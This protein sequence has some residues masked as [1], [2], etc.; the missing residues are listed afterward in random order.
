MSEADLT[1]PVAKAATF[2]VLSEPEAGPPGARPYKRRRVA[3]ATL[4]TV[5]LLLLAAAPSA[6]A[7]PTV[8]FLG[9]RGSGEGSSGFGK[10]VGPVLATVN[11]QLSYVNVGNWSE[12]S[13]YPAIPVNP[14]KPTFNSDYIKSVDDGVAGLHSEVA[15]FLSSCSHT[16]LLLAG[17][18][19]GAEVVDDWLLT[20]NNGGSNVI[21]VALL[22]DPRFNTNNSEDVGTNRSV[23]GIAPLQFADWDTFPYTTGLFSPP[24]PFGTWVRYPNSY[25]SSLRSFCVSGDP[26][27]GASSIGRVLSCLKNDCAHFHYMTLDVPSSLLTVPYKGETYTT[28]AGLWLAQRFAA[29]RTSTG[30]GSGPGGGGTGGPGGGGGGGPTPGGGVPAG[31]VAETA[32][33]TVNTWSN[34]TNAGGAEGAQILRGATVGV[35]CKLQGLAVPDGNTW[36]YLVASSPWSGQFYASADAFYNNGQTSGSL[37]GT[38]FVDSAV[39][40]C[41]GGAGGQPMSG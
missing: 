13:S 36:W 9:V 14:L 19:Q 6:F 40:D 29:Y 26:I 38:A 16:P 8:Q 39:P 5:L 24:S 18:S 2:V 12:P 28:A 15:R 10:T 17:Y 20:D 27:C 11:R 23:N 33:G 41:S 25:K 37:A 7:C 4:A 32:G 1:W 31:S 3:S 34:Y 35:S 30:G 22:G 21:G